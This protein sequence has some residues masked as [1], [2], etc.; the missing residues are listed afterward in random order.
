MI[1]VDVI[2]IR[3]KVPHNQPIVVLKEHDGN[4]Y[5]PI[6]IGIVEASAIG[7]AMQGVDSPRPM[8]HD[9]FVQTLATLN[10]VITGVDIVDLQEGT[11]FAELF[12]VSPDGQTHVI[13]A[14]PSDAIAL[15]VRLDIPVR[16][17]ETVMDDASTT[18][19]ERDEEEQIEEFKAFLDQVNPE[20]FQ[21]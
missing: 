10:G 19:E 3:V 21:D 16:V 12:L 20:D 14:R 8:T 4:R 5:L 11:F 18:I 13:D 15:A 2:G 9:L 17:S 7:L 1:D 6:W